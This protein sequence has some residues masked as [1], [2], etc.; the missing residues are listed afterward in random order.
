MKNTKSLYDSCR[1]YFKDAA[2]IHS[3]NPR[4]GFAIKKFAVD[5]ISTEY[6]KNKSA[7]SG[8]ELKEFEGVV[9]ELSEEKKQ[10]GIKR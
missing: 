7:L 5:K 9:R 6:M 8:P 4:I 10:L 1:I 2:L 3:I